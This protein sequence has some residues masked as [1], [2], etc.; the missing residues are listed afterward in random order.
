MVGIDLPLIWA[1][2]L[3]FGVFMYVLLDGFDLGIGILFP[4]APS[5]SGPRPDDEHGRAD[6]GRQRDLAGARRRRAAGGVP[7]RLRDLLPALYLPL[8]LMLLALIFRGVAF[9][10]RFKANTE[11]LLWDHS[12]SSSARWSRRSPGR[13]R[14]APSSRAFRWRDR[15]FAGGTFDWLDAVRAVQRRWRWLPAMRCWAHLA[16]HE[17]GRRR[18]R[19]GPT[20]QAR[21]RSSWCV[22]RLHRGGQHLDAA[23]PCG[24]PRAGSP[25][26]TSCSCSRRCPLVT[27]VH[28]LLAAGAR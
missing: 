10:F 26:P 12:L 16:D 14:S 6:L 18:C 11:P 21:D 4:F 9:E 3:G 24:S 22:R 23:D 15:N 25:G 7:A 5:D 8:L 17:D 28:R 2:I 20:H 13:R 1:G 27:A 19:T